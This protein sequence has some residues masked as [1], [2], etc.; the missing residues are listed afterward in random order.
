M[1]VHAFRRG[2]TL[3]ELLVVIAI[4][5]ILVGLL[6]PA[7]N[8]ARES[9]R[10]TQCQNN[11]RNVGPGIIVVSSAR[12][13][14]AARMA[15]ASVASFSR[16]EMRTGRGGSSRTR[17]ARTEHQLRSYLTTK[18]SFP[19]S[20]RDPGG[21]MFF[22][23]GAVRFITATIDGTSYA[24]MITPA[25][26]RIQLMRSSF[27]SPRCPNS[28]ECWLFKDADPGPGRSRRLATGR[29]GSIGAAK[30]GVP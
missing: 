21:N 25:G 7:I 27:R 20:Q 29:T 13:R 6:L 30:S 11:M 24:K 12:P 17:S 10:R 4:I 26:A 3:I 19:F 9:G 5:A 18:G 23:D 16:W 14:S 2:F 28:C 15:L 22:C 1:K 8:A